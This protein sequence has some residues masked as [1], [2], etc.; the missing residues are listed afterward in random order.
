MQFSL[1]TAELGRGLPRCI[2]ASSDGESA[3]L[4]MTGSQT[5]VSHHYAT[6]CYLSVHLPIAL[7]S[8]LGCPVI[9]VESSGA[10]FLSFIP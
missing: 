9:S 2:P 7:W 10:S 5:E 4:R 3:A 8:E 1:H 6:L